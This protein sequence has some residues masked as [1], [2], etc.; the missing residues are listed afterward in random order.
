ML[1]NQDNAIKKD[2]PVILISLAVIVAFAAGLLIGTQ[3]VNPVTNESSEPYSQAYLQ[4]LYSKI[5]SVYLG[6]M[7]SVD[8]VTHKMAAGM[9]AALNDEHSAFLSPQEAEDYLDSNASTFEG[10]GVQLGFNGQYTIVS[11]PLEGYPA[12]AAGMRAGDWVLEVDGEDMAGKRP[13]IVATYIRGEAGTSVELIVYREADSSVLNFTVERKEID[14]ENITYKQLDNGVVV[15][16]IVKFT[17][18]E[19]SNLDGIQV[20]VRDW[21]RVVDE[22]AE[23]QPKGIVVDLRNNPGGYVDAVVYV[24][25]EFLSE[26]EVIMREQTKDDQEFLFKDDRTGSLEDIPLVVLVNE[27]SAS[28]AE[29]FAAAMQDNGRAKIVGMPTV[30][31]GVEQRLIQMQDGG[32]LLVVFKKWLTPNGVN[33]DAESPIKPDVEL[34]LTP[35]DMDLIPGDDIDSQLEKAIELLLT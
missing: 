2:V 27:A 11:T 17:E 18:G 19:D 14:L 31:K 26:G 28:S 9:V 30:G 29:I 6:D 3:Q 5:A 24:A 21:D 15:I 32:L 12:Q 22:V 35:E 34:E 4:D 8:D 23:L 16:D 7:P 25:E 33:I 20:F 10:I 1:M 13:E